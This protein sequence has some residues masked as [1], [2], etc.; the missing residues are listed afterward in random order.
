M[1][2]FT[3]FVKQQLGQSLSETIARRRTAGRPVAGPQI[4]SIAFWTAI[5]LGVMFGVLG[6]LLFSCSSV[7]GRLG[8]VPNSETVG[9]DLVKAYVL[10]SG[11]LFGLLTLVHVW[12]VMEEGPGLA[13]DPWYVLITLVAAAL[14]VWAFRLLRIMTR[15]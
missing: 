6:P 12:R 4:Q 9:G 11:L 1:K 3:S 7:P 13:S 2:S 10:T 14:C 8:E 5:S 15:E